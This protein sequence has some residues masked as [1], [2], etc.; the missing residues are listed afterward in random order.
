MRFLKRQSTSNKNALGKAVVYDINDQVI[1]DSKNV[2][3]V[4]KGTT[5]ERPLS[6]EN[7]HFRYNVT[8]E[9]FEAYQD[10][11]WR[12]VRYKEPKRVVQQTLAGATGLET[13]FGPLDNQDLDFP[14]GSSADSQTLTDVAQSMIVLIENVFQISTTNYNIVQNPSTPGVG[15]E[16]EAANLVTG[17]EYIITASND[18]S[19]GVSTDFTTVGASD[20]N[21][22]TVFIATGSAAG[23]GLVRETGYYLEFTSGVPFGKPVTVLHNFNK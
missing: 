16:V 9:E 11:Q 10:S 20:S 2:M 1:L 7:G 19:G 18:G 22:G 15:A 5:A 14:V 8:T 17:T 12:K 4:P 13:I 23:T 6:P 21:Q 3:L